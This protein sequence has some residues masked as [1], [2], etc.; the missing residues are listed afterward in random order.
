[1]NMMVMCI[2]ILD[3]GLVSVLLKEYLCSVI[4]DL[5]DHGNAC[6]TS[7]L[8]LS[9]AK[10]VCSAIA[11]SLTPRFKT[12]SLDA[13]SRNSRKPSIII[14]YDDPNCFRSSITSLCSAS[15]AVSGNTVLIR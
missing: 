1:M 10:H 7:I 2:S 3:I 13:W 11:G 6:G 5:Y 14:M 4:N 8:A 9:A 15:T 12:I